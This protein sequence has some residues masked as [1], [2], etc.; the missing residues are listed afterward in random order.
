MDGARPA[1]AVVAAFLRA[2]QGETL[3]QKVEQGSPRINLDL[4]RFTVDRG[5]QQQ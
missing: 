3:T 5:V 2:G 4:Q 1:L